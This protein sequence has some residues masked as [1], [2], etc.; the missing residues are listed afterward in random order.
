MIPAFFILGGIVLA[1]LLV[2]ID[3][4]IGGGTPDNT[5]M[6]FFAVGPDGA[7]GILSAI[8]STVLSVATMAF[9][10]TIS[11][12]S[13]ASSSFGP[14]LVRNFMSDRGNQVVL[15]T[16]TA[17]FLYCLLVMRDV[18]GAEVSATNQAFVPHIA[19]NF[20]VALALACVGV[21][22]YFINHIASGIQVNTIATTVQGK[23]ADLVEKFY[24]AEPES[25]EITEGATEIRPQKAF[26]Y[27]VTA[28]KNGYVVDVE[29]LQLALKIK[30]EP[31]D[32]EVLIRPGDH[33]I[34][35]ERIALLYSNSELT[36]D[37]IDA[38]CD[39]VRKSCSVGTART[40]YNDV[41]F[42][43]EQMIEL[44]VRAL[45]PGTND[46]YTMT[47]AAHELT[48]GLVKAAQC[49][50]LPNAVF[51]GGQARI[52]HTPVTPAEL[53]DLVFDGIRTHAIANERAVIDLLTIAGKL[54]ALGTDPAAL[55]RAR[56]HAAVLLDA[57]QETKPNQHNLNLVRAAYDKAVAAEA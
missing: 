15:G 50:E 14:R 9:S 45:S 19:V 48:G 28:S 42:V 34:E 23:F 40:D 53:V 22:I 3:R 54:L 32:V 11:V 38:A 35:G 20:S 52:F 17:T 16:F 57:Y 49:R 46:P 47:N 12:M 24:H 44:G 30:D 41:R 4:A 27:P 56:W 51:I 26:S 8:S 33:L 36:Q 1:Q 55:A 21:L 39:V 5:S 13:S 10:I 25:G 37:E 6:F 7:R 29:L 43:A 31:L 2:S 18:H